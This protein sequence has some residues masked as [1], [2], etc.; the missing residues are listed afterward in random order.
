M[1]YR[2]LCLDK[3]C[4]LGK[5]RNI[6]VFIIISV[7]CNSNF[8]L[9]LLELYT[10][11]LHYA[12]PSFVHTTYEIRYNLICNHDGWIIQYKHFKQCTNQL[13]IQIQSNNV[14]LADQSNIII[15]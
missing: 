12:Q 11:I 7:L 2:Y 3:N 10:N 14:Q 6:C 4:I 8:E 15:R 13:A 5:S 9:I 1:L